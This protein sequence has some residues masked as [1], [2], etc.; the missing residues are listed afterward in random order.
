MRKTVRRGDQVADLALAGV[1]VKL[2][3]AEKPT[4]FGVGFTL[5]IGLL[6]V[7]VTAWSLTTGCTG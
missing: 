4:R 1:A 7:Y 3:E 5:F 6:F 2:A